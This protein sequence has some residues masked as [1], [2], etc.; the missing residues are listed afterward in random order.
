VIKRGAGMEEPGVDKMILF[1]YTIEI[2]TTQYAAI[3]YAI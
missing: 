3:T 1:R 2:D